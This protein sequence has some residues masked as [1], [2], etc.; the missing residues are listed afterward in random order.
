MWEV[1]H[2]ERTG[3]H[4]IKIGMR[5]SREEHLRTIFSLFGFWAAFCVLSLGGKSRKPISFSVIVVVTRTSFWIILWPRNHFHK[6]PR[7]RLR[8]S[9]YEPVTKSLILLPKKQFVLLPHSLIHT[10]NRLVNRP[11]D[12]YYKRTLYSQ[13]GYSTILTTLLKMNVFY[14]GFSQKFFKKVFDESRIKTNSS[15]LW[16]FMIE[17]QQITVYSSSL[18]QK[19]I[20]FIFFSF[21]FFLVTTR[22]YYPIFLLLS[23]IGR[24]RYQSLKKEWILVFFLSHSLS[25][26]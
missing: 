12:S 20:L 25:C 21:R 14:W 22:S 19:E 23:V 7:G 24:I 11:Y 6:I 4:T 8:A 15:P 18:F 9:V 10:C 3:W 13:R 5:H 17:S 2:L 1:G 16:A 26:N